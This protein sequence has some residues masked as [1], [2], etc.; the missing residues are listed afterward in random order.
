MATREWSAP[1]EGKCK[2]LQPS[3]DYLGHQVD[4]EGMHTMVSKLRATV[5]ARVL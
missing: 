4:A 3:V 1:Q 2:F 5:H